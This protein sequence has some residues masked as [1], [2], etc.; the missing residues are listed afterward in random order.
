[1]SA[2]QRLDQVAERLAACL[3]VAELVERGGGRRQ[4]DDLAGLVVVQGGGARL[5]ERSGQVAA[6]AQRNLA[7]ERL[8]ESGLGLADQEGLGDA[9]QQGVDAIQAAVLGA[10]LLAR[11]SRRDAARGAENRPG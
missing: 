10:V 7:V 9:G 3:E 2:G 6:A 11:A 1:M 8:G 5:I 4:Q